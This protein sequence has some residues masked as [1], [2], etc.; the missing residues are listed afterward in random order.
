MG[1]IWFDPGVLQETIIEIIG[2]KAGLTMSAKEV[3]KH[4]S[5][6]EFRE[7]WENSA[8]SVIR[9]RSEEFEMLVLNILKEIGNISDDSPISPAAKMLASKTEAASEEMRSD[10]LHMFEEWLPVAAQKAKDIGS[11]ALDPTPLLSAVMA[12]HGG[13]GLD[14]MARFL[15]AV[16]ESTHRNPW[17]GMRRVDWTDTADL[18][19][20][21]KSESL[22]TLYGD[23]I[24]QRYIDYLNANLD[25]VGKMNWRKFE[26][27]SAEF[28]SREGFHV[29]I[30][31][32]R[33][34]GGIDIRVWPNE[35][36]SESSP[37][38]IM[39]QCKRQKGD[40]EQVVVKALWADMVD[41][42][43]SSGL[44]VTSSRLAPGAKQVCTAR[45]YP[46]IGVERDALCKWLRALRTP[47]ADDQE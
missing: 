4:I 16:N 32:G 11:K 46:I 42:G 26:G 12:K 10:L 22:S 6:S 17:G 41:E 19:D 37:P 14:F 8:K 39:I 33:S 1:A 29:V 40:V 9:I 20:L 21:F 35:K 18:Q 30:G 5:R 25:L 24:D 44:I 43:A 3:S 45:S 36:A 23:F 28:F 15:K 13:I 27:L 38:L 47:E 7:I 31:K 34:D 2:F